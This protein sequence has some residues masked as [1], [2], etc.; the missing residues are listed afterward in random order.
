MIVGLGVDIAEVDRIE[1]AIRR[2]G[3]AFLKRVFTEAEIAYCERHRLKNLQAAGTHGAPFAAPR[4]SLRT[5][6]SQSPNIRFHGR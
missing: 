6:F 1:A 2:H 5:R 4:R 3:E